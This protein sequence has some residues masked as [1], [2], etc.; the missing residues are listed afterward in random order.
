MELQVGKPLFP[1]TQSQGSVEPRWP[2]AVY[3]WVGGWA[4]LSLLLTRPS[5]DGGA[6]SLSLLCGTP[7]HRGWGG[8]WSRGLKEE[9]SIKG[10]KP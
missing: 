6:P 10:H 9:K 1:P 2:Q 8:I 5:L 4:P 7:C 3:L